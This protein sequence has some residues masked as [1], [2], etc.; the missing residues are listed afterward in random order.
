M[1]RIQGQ[2]LDLGSGA[3]GGLIRQLQV[4]SEG[5]GGLLRAPELLVAARD[6]EPQHRARGD[7][8]DQRL[9]AFELREGVL[10]LFLHEEARAQIDVGLSPL[11]VH[12]GLRV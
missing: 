6:V 4:A 10:E 5:E 7:I 2:E 8:G 12:R 11:G 3:G 1:P 9:G